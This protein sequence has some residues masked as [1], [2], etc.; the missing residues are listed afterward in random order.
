MAAISCCWWTIFLAL[1]RVDTKSTLKFSF[2]F[3]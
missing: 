3:I 2:S 1:N